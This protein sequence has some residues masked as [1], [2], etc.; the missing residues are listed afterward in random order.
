MRLRRIEAVRYGA[1]ANTSLGDLGAGLTVVHGPN[2]AGKSSYTSLVRHVLYGYPNLRDSEGGYHVPGE[3][4]CARLVFDDGDGSWVVE[5]TEGTHGGTLRVK[6]LAGPDAPL[7]VDELVRGVSARTFRTVFGFGLDQ[8]A[9]IAQERGAEDG[10]VARLYAAGAGL[11]VNPQEVRAAI[12]REAAELFKP[13]GRKQPVNELAGELRAVRAELRELRTKADAYL[14]DQARLREMEEQL[15]RARLS[16]DAAHERSTELAVALERVDER[17]AAIASYEE[18]LPELLRE[19]ARLAEEAAALAPDASLLAVAPEIDALLEEAAGHARTLQSLADSEAAVVRAETRH[20][21][22]VERT[23]LACETLESLEESHDSA[24]VIEQTR[25]ELQR[26]EML[27]ATREEAI[28]RAAAEL[29][30]TEVERARVLGPLGIDH[31]DP[32]EQIA[33]RLA[34]VEA[35]ESARGHQPV[36]RGH[37]VP[38]LILLASGLVGIVTGLV[39]SQWLAAAIGA[40]MGIAGVFFLLRASRGAPVMPERD[41]R[42][43]LR[44]LGLE[45]TAGPLELSRVRRALE[46]ARAADAEVAAARRG[47][48]EA[49]LEHG[50]GC[51]AL[52]TRLAL[53]SEWLRDSGL[54]E[55]LTPSAAASVLALAREARG[56]RSLLDE[57]RQSHAHCLGQLDAFASRFGD[58]AGPFLG[59]QAPPAREEVPTLANRLKE[60]LAEARSRAARQ[61]AIA[62]EVAALDMR[63]A[64]EGDRAERARTDL[65]EVLERFDLAEG[66]TH[67]DLRVLH[68]SARRAEAEATAAYDELSQTK[69]QLEGR[70]ESGARD[71]RT[72]ELHLEESALG[73]RLAETIDRYLVLSLASRLLGE[74]QAR[75]QRERQPEVVRR[76]GE[77]FA[78]MTD[79]RYVGL[80]VP[81][82]EGDIE[83][84]DAHTGVRTSDILSRGT[85]EQLYLAVRLG[86]IS[87]LGDVGKGLPVIMDDVLV[88]FDPGRRRGAAAAIAQ[89]AS[90]RQ[91]L[92]FTCHPETADLLEELAPGLTRLEL[93]RQG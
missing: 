88:N 47:L 61:E 60:Q 83:V 69:H 14:E 17:R 93:A 23:G 13:T 91:V 16:R 31:P 84:I 7:L 62:R 1:L 34:A 86:L 42:A 73:E 37:D 39:L 41:D 21:D 35:L 12:E 68:S 20:A 50:L 26:L 92:F 87:Q 67:E 33:E 59:L 45:V 11:R 85:A 80:T 49:Q 19:K 9:A 38:S 65:L 63:I 52:Q 75:Y 77:I 2:E 70:L 55:T 44:M 28:R 3:G 76:A 54:D 4:R 90:E 6:A 78:S 46:A 57:A 25:E 81:L 32:G 64:A 22:A 40:L 71:R 89:L 51:D 18:A 43:Y 79:G 36:T 10:V 66:G 15:E 72:G 30:R 5:R 74:A 48:E 24:S 29:E 53:W 58:V 82:G 8:M 56:Q 27:C